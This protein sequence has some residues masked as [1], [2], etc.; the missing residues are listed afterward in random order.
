MAIMAPPP[1]SWG[2]LSQGKRVKQP[3]L[4]VPLSVC[5]GATAPEGVFQIKHLADTHRGH[6][7]GSIDI[8]VQC[9]AAQFTC[10][11]PMNLEAAVQA[12]LLA[13][14]GHPLR[15]GVGEKVLPIGTKD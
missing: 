7:Q 15:R 8:S 5:V 13:S 9:L 4:C 10:A 3:P 12:N 6:V 1:P 11:Q 14:L 2:L